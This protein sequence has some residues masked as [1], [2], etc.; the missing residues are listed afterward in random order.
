MTEYDI[1]RNL[2]GT[3]TFEP[4]QPHN[5]HGTVVPLQAMR[6]AILQIHSLPYP[7]ILFYADTTGRGTVLCPLG[8]PAHLHGFNTAQ[9]NVPY[10]IE[11][12]PEDTLLYDDHSHGNIHVTFVVMRTNGYRASFSVPRCPI[13]YSV[14]KVAH[15]CINGLRAVQPKIK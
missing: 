14:L 3:I 15:Q 12:Y 8:E 2:D 9:S 13:G 1:V 11:L 7:I 4:K 10:Y 5:R 6:D